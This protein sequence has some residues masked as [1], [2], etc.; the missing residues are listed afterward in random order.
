MMIGLKGGNRRVETGWVR[1]WPPPPGRRPAPSRSEAVRQAGRDEDRL[2]QRRRAVAGL[3]SKT[4]RL[5][6]ERQ[7]VSAA[8][9]IG[10]SVALGLLAAWLGQR[11]GAAL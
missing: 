7:L 2:A 9:N 6:E 5:A 4:Q 8:A 10:V 3:L 1:G 11:L